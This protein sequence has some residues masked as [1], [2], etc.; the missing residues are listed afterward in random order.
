LDLQIISEAS[1][2]ITECHIVDLMTSRVS[3][4]YSGQT[5]VPG[6]SDATDFLVVPIDYVHQQMNNTRVNKFYIDLVDG[7][8]Y[9]KVMN[10]IVAIA[11]NSLNDIESSL[12]S[13]DEVLDSRATQSI[14]GTYTLNVLFSLIYLT[15]GMIIVSI[16]R[17]RG[18]RKQFSVLRAL[19][20][21]NK[22]IILASLAETSIGILIA[23]G[24]GGL[25]GGTLAIL[26]MNVPLLHM[27]T[28]TIGLWNR[29]PVQLV[30]PL[31]LISLIV[32]IAVGASLLATY[33]V[34]IRTLKLNIAEEIQYNE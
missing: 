12:A 27:G 24:I 32:G 5:F 1:N 28:A 18:L 6:E 13:I 34:L 31:P 30:L 25:I 8:N 33:Y 20:A 4:S 10:D 16:V 9:T 7:A 11:P 19:G 3:D 14:Y 29:L 2:N 22:S 26:L 17:V 21:P 15:I 23:A